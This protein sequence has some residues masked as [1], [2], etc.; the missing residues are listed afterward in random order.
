MVYQLRRLQNKI[1]INWSGHVEL[2]ASMSNTQL[3]IK[4]FNTIKHLPPIVKLNMS[5]TF[6]AMLTFIADG[7]TPL[8]IKHS[9]LYSKVLFLNRVHILPFLLLQIMYVI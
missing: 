2:C 1:A 8:T 6:W 9:I 5:D 7:A 4:C 3:L